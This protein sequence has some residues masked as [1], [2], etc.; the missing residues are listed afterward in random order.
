MPMNAS[1]LPGIAGIAGLVRFSSQDAGWSTVLLILP[2]MY[3]TYLRYRLYVER[4]MA[5]SEIH[6]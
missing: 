2:I 3:G 4:Q 6:Q 5:G 1:W